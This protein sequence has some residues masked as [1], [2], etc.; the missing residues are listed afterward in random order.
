MPFPSPYPTLLGS[1]PA[2]EGALGAAVAEAVVQFPDLALVV[3]AVPISLV[4]IDETTSPPDFLHG[5][6]LYGRT[7]FSA[8]LLKVAAMYAAFELRKSVNARGA[9]ADV[10]RQNLFSILNTEFDPVIDS[11][12]PAISV[13]AGVTPAMRVPKYREIFAVMDRTTGG[14]A[15]EFNAT[16]QSNM[17]AMIVDSNNNA[18]A[19][20][21]Q[22]LGY[23]WINGT[24]QKGGFFLPPDNGIWLAGTFTGSWPYVRIPS[25]NDGPVAQATTCFDMANLYAHIVR[26]TLVDADASV[27]MSKLL[28]DAATIGPDASFMDHARRQREGI[29]ARSF[30]ITHNKVGLAPL[31][32]GQ[33]VASEATIVIHG[34]T[35]R[36]FL[37]VWQNC[38]ANIAG[39]NAMAFIVDRGIELFIAAHP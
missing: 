31:K 23:S 18:A 15:A 7:Y 14:I 34:P 38:P 10:N 36:K 8:S 2:M 16:F 19:A 28:A 39:Y 3:G 22:A 25:D 30:F 17:R 9:A 29:I 24:L 1:D 5:G 20:C 35:D 13:A 21:V 32:T 26:R 27:R 33:M 12:I 6:I 37:T 11:A 4:A